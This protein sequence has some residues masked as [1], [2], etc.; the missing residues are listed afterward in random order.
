MNLLIRSAARRRHILFG[1][2]LFLQLALARCS[3]LLPSLGHLLKL[4][5]MRRDRGSRH[6]A[7]FGGMFAVFVEFFHAVPLTSRLPAILSHVPAM[8]SSMM[9]C[10]SSAADFANSRHAVA[11]ARQKSSDNCWVGSVMNPYG[12]CG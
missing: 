8:C 3:E 11:S 7:A 6:V 12:C 9:R 5:P 4:L 10:G 1:F 2:S